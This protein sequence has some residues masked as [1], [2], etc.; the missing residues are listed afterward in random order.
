MKKYELY[1]DRI[2]EVG[3]NYVYCIESVCELLNS[4][5]EKNER[6]EKINHRN[7]QK[8]LDTSQENEKLKEIIRETL[9]MARRYA[10]GRC[11]YAPE[12]VNKC[13]DLALELGIELNG[14]PEEMYAKDG[15]FGEWDSR[16]KGFKNESKS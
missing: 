2:K 3:S 11:T 4:Y 16:L 6:L 14:P 9:W 13:I 15:M 1:L 5:F 8:T 12:T 10:D 7:Y